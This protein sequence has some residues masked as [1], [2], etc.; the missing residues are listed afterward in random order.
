[1]TLWVVVSKDL[2]FL[3]F[4]RGTASWDQLDSMAT[5]GAPIY[6]EPVGYWVE[7]EQTGPGIRMVDP[8]TGEWFELVGKELRKLEAGQ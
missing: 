4:R 1:V 7:A 6:T 2:K 5:G 8:Y 3:G